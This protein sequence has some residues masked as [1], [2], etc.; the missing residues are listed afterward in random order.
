MMQ[1]KEQ[2][3]RQKHKNKTAKVS[4]TTQEKFNAALDP[5][6]APFHTFILV[7]SVVLH[8]LSM[9]Y[10]EPFVVS[11]GLQRRFVAFKS[12]VAVSSKAL[13]LGT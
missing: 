12:K 5:S 3:R 8:V 2:S 13:Q 10:D 1:G 4:G 6:S 7:L 9:V 11:L